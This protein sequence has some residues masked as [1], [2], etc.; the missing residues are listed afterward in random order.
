MDVADQLIDKIISLV[1]LQKRCAKKLD[2]VADELENIKKGCNVAKVVGSSVSVGGAAA[3]MG[4][5]ILSVV[6]GGAAIPVLAAA[7]TIATGAGLATNV[8]SDVTDL[9][10]SS[11]NM[12]E[13]KE[14]AEEIE[15]LEKGVQKLMETLKK[16]GQKRENLVHSRIFSSEDYVV[17]MI[18]RA[19]A[20]REGLTLNDGVSLSLMLSVL[21]T[22][23]SKKKG[24]DFALLGLSL[25][26]KVAMIAVRKSGK[27]LA[28]NGFPELAKAMGKKAA[29]K[30]VGRVRIRKFSFQPSRGRCLLYS[31]VVSQHNL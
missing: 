22:K 25:I 7:G 26:Y 29:G 8:V 18:L 3:L 17:E 14:T 28:S 20:K 9:I 4:A 10:A 30:A 6:T 1:E 19:M 11:C 24:E 27:S 12:K 21:S 2:H 5:G 16:E 13:A 23:M 31:H 15:N